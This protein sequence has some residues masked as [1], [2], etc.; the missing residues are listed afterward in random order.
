MKPG[1]NIIFILLLLIMGVCGGALVGAFLGLTH[2]LPQIRALND[3][4]PSSVTRILADDGSLLSELYI[5]NRDP[6][7][8]DEMPPD[9]LAAII[10]TE[11]RKFF[12]HSGI[13]VK[14]ILRA[15]VRDI[16]GR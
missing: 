16:H 6:V 3:F 2:D 7:S 11:D 4:K 10:T 8:I 15:A 14:G 1:R 12:T 13:D 9:L 5:E